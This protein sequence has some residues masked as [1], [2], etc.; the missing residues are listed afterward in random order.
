MNELEYYIFVLGRDLLVKKLEN[1]E[2]DV[3]YD[4]CSKV[5]KL[6]LKSTEYT[7]YN[8][9][10]YESLENFIHNYYDVVSII[11]CDVKHGHK[12]FIYH[13]LDDNKYYTAQGLRNLLIK[14]ELHDIYNNIDMYQKRELDIDFKFEEL[15]EIN[16]LC[17]EEVHRRLESYWCYSL[18]KIE[19]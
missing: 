2:N 3:A 19:L 18:N 16:S 4:A 14:D 8:F 13:D 5:A 15:K 11:I 6:F 1:V 9:S 10:G 7:D 17:I 12:V